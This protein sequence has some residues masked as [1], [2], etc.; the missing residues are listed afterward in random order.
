MTDTT[1]STLPDEAIV[2]G[3][4]AADWRAAVRLA[5]DALVASGATTDAYT[6]EMIE[7][8]ETLGP[9]IVI[10]PGFALAHSRP[11]PAVL[12]TGLSWVQLR[13]PVAFGHAKNDPVDLVAGLAAV[14]HDS[15]LDI[16]STLARALADPAVMK[17]LREMG[18]A[19]DVRDALGLD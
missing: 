19:D 8:I 15:H 14:D 3:A 2:L 13:E 6:D 11:S 16:M 9:Y 1:G 10:A 5:G 7:T 18:D 17:L 12:R 4:T